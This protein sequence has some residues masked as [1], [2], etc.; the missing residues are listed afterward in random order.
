MKDFFKADE[1]GILFKALSHKT[2][3]FKRNDCKETILLKERLI[4]LLCSSLLEEKFPP[5]VT[6]NSKRLRFF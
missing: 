1:T 4:I 2:L 5:L 6:R 3:E